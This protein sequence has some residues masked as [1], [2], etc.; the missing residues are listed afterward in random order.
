M[1]NLETKE[2]TETAKVVKEKTAKVVK[3]KT[4]LNPFEKGVSYD[5]FKKEL[6]TTKVAE[7]CKGH[8]TDDQI[9]WIEN[10]LKILI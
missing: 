3:E 4:F 8:L 1:E 2:N 10:E 5:D 6:G 9:E 7:Y